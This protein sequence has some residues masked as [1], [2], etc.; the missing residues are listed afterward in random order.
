MKRP[1]ILVF[2]GALLFSVAQAQPINPAQYPEKYGAVGDGVHD[3]TAAF[4][5]AFA[6]LGRSG[7]TIHLA[8]KTY[9]LTGMI[10]IAGTGYGIQINGRSLI[11]EGAA[12]VINCRPAFQLIACFRILNGSDSSI[13]DL[14]ILANANVKYGLEITTLPESTERVYVTHLSIVGGQ[15]GIAIG[16]DTHNDVSGIVMDA[17]NASGMSG[18]GFLIGDGIS[19][20]VLNWTCT[21][22]GSGENAY[23]VYVNG[24]G[25]TWQGG[26]VGHNTIADFYVRQPNSDPITI[27]GVRSEES[28]RFLYTNA[29]GATPVTI[30]DCIVSG[31]HA[32]D[33]HV[34]WFDGGAN[35]PLF[36]ENSIFVNI[37]TAANV[38]IPNNG[39]NPW[40]ITLLSVGT[41]NPSFASFAPVGAANVHLFSVNDYQTNVA[42]G[43]AVL[44]GSGLMHSPPS[45][46]HLDK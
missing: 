3:D 9:L 31:F 29:Q 36:I 42:S 45:A 25:F 23:G 26:S 39:G 18:A 17:V 44:S 20:N 46:Q 34:I 37:K 11:G 5:A 7:G 1:L 43:G 14:Y 38:N 8:A 2:A 27:S 4:R 41:S 12:T 10:D 19:G 24:S 21:G 30:R 13:R 35:L 16:P 33:G 22:C 32:A 15:N 6:A 40:N 28:N